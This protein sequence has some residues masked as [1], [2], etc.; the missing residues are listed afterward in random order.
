MSHLRPEDRSTKHRRSD[1]K[2]GRHIYG[3][4]QSIGGGIRRQVCTECGT[5]TIDLSGADE[6]TTPVRANGTI[7]ATRTPEQSEAS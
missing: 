6:L 4:A 2:K 3:E 7:A 5:V 1:C